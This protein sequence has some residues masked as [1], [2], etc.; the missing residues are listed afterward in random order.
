MP[1][2]ERE[3][4]YEYGLKRNIGNKHGKLS[5]PKKKILISNGIN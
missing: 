1:G 2:L 3:R 4:K 5:F